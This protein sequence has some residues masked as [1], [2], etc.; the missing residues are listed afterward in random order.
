[1]FLGRPAGI[2]P[3]E[4]D[5][6]FP[7]PE[8]FPTD[9][10]GVVQ[11]DCRQPNAYSDSQPAELLRSSHNLAV[12]GREGHRMADTRGGQQSQTDDILGGHRSGP[13]SPHDGPSRKVLPN[14]CRTGSSNSWTPTQGVD[15]DNPP[16]IR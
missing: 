1:M 12:Y 3:A 10:N 16:A 8:D 15:R 2:S 6:K 5:T 7:M 11:K 4:F 14:N 13:D 9:E